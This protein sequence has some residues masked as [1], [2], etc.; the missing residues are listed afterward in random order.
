V[1]AAGYAQ[2]AL[3]VGQLARRLGLAGVALTLEGG[4][5]LVALR[6]SVAATVEGLLAG[7]VGEDPT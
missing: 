2:A 7:M 1:T 3:A 5:A 4:Y 6:E